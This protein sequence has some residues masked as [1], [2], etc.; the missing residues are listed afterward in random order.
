[1]RYSLLLAEA[2]LNSVASLILPSQH[3]WGIWSSTQGWLIQLGAVLESCDVLCM[4]AFAFMINEGNAEHRPMDLVL[5]RK[6]AD[7]TP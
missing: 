6:R 5:R 2:S 1:M 4:H 3:D 7:V